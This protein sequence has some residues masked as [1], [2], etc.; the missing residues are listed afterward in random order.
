[1]G[2]LKIDTTAAPLN[3]VGA[4]LYG[5]DADGLAGY[6]MNTQSTPPSGSGIEIMPVSST[7]LWTTDKTAALS[8]S[9]DN[10]VTFMG[11]PT[12]KITIPAG[13]SGTCKV[14]CSSA[15]ALVPYNWDRNDF[16]IATMYSGFTGYN[17]TTTFPPNVVAYLG[18]ASYSNFWT[19][20]GYVGSNFPEQQPRQGEWWIKKSISNEFTASGSPS[21]SANM[22]CK[23]QWTQV[24]QAT[25]CVIYVGFFGRM[26]PRKKPT[27]IWTLDDGYSSWSSFVA[28][29]FK[30]YDMP[31]S[32]GIDSALVG[33]ANYM[34]SAQILS[35]FKDETRLFD[36]V[37]HGVSN[38]SYNSVGA[39]QYYQNLETTR[40]YMQNLGI[41]GPGPYHH[42][43]V[44]SVWG[45][46]L[47][48]LMI[49]GGYLSGRAANSGVIGHGKD[50]LITEDKD[51]WLT[52]ILS[53]LTNTKS[54]AQAKTDVDW[55]VSNNTFGMINAHD[56]VDSGPT[57][58]QWTKSD[59]QQLV[60]YVAALRDS[61]SLEVKSWSRWY[62]DLTGGNTDRR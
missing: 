55:C 43:Y 6:V 5:Q 18:D 14:G 45:N 58:Y 11:K 31:V 13:T 32:M 42:P 8:L 48:D 21:V 16:A 28:P 22:R 44:Q 52:N 40:Q 20:N 26:A 10:D 34:T 47:L 61:G 30:H 3:P 36:F 56:F 53:A 27:I 23:L 59:M 19:T 7:S 35:L 33:T 25:D 57:T 41:Y 50:G 29:L 49:N 46:D 17:M 2:T 39:S 1:M 9:V 51:R 60:G 37:N 62:A 15:L 4:K 24:A 38:Q 12:L 54:L